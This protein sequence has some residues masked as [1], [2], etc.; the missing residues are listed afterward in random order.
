MTT[1]CLNIQFADIKISGVDKCDLYYENEFQ[2]TLVILDDSQ[3]PYNSLRQNTFSL[4]LSNLE[5]NIEFRVRS[6]DNQ[7]F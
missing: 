4:K 2:T 3:K 7:E 6:D 5:S 1:Y